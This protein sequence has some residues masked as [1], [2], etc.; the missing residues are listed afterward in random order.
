MII[1][2]LFYDLYNYMIYTIINPLHTSN[3]CKI[4]IIKFIL[5]ECSGFFL[6]QNEE[7]MAPS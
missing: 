3:F 4:I 6:A 5:N 2:W 7:E 1:T